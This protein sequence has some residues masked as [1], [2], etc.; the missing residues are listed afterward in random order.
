L[1]GIV[2]RMP[3]ERRTPC[4][5]RDLIALSTDPGEV[6]GLVRCTSA[7]IFRR[8]Y[9]PSGVIRRTP[10]W[11]TVQAKSR[12]WLITIASVIVLAATGR[13]ACAQSR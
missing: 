4:R 12:T 11:S 9:R 6:C 3:F 1:A 5:D 13:L 7:V 2:V 8:P 10:S